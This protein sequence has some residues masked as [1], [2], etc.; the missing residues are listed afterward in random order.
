MSKPVPSI[1]IAVVLFLVLAFLD[2]PPWA[3]VGLSTVIFN[4]VLW[5][6]NG[7]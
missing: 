1:T 7:Q 2:A 3:I 5:G 4:V 6:S